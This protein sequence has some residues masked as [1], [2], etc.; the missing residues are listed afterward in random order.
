MRT[1]SGFAALAG[2]V[3]ATTTV[4]APAFGQPIEPGREGLLGALVS[5]VPGRSACYARRYDAAHLR[6]HPDQKVT[7]LALRIAYRREAPD[8]ANP[9]GQRYYDFTASVTLRGRKALLTSGECAL[10]EGAIVCGIECDGGGFGLTK[11]AQ[12]TLLLDLTRFGRLRLGMSC[13]ERNHPELEPGR[14]DK[15]FRLQA[16]AAAQCAFPAE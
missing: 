6:K 12:G 1:P 15:R 13:D 16:A 8:T 10:R 5:P 3:L 14:D 4:A 2:L 11:E 7:A 9:A